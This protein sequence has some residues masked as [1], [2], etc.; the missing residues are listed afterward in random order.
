MKIKSTITI[1]IPAFDE[2]ANIGFILQDLLKQK[3][4]NNSYIKE[5]IVYSDASTDQT[6]NIVKK[7]QKKHPLIK[8]IVG[9]IRVG[10]GEGMNKIFS[11]A[12]SD[13]L[14]ILDA[15]ILIKDKYFIKRITAPII[16]GE[17]D[18]SS[19][20]QKEL[21]PKKFMEKIV[22]AG[23]QI[24][25]DIYWSYN[26]GQNLYTCHGHARAFSKKLYQDLRF[27][28]IPGE[29]AFSYLYCIYHGYRYK[30]SS[31][32]ESWYKLPGSFT[33]HDKQSQRFLNSIKQQEKY[34]PARFVR[35]QYH[36][37]FL[38]SLTIVAKHLISNPLYS[39]LYFSVLAISQIKSLFYRNYNF[40]KW[41]LATSS[42]VIRH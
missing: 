22:F 33:D 1:G 27:P 12:S 21:P 36:L 30:F 28:E 20:L 16:S 29:D 11:T 34:F 5:I 38:M 9:K 17:A 13:V 26:Q 4:S 25:N 32:P 24:K 35:Q 14:V 37:P 15:D 8:L 39:S 2:E 42:K 7:F 3:V 23:M 41:D 6:E 18:L 10:K 40:A 19:V 31:P